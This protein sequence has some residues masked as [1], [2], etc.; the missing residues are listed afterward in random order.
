MV[1]NASTTILLAKTKL[2][3]TID[4]QFDDV[5][6]STEVYR[7]TV[8]EPKLRYQDAAITEGE[9]GDRRIKVKEVRDS[10]LVRRLTE[11][12][13]MSKGEAETIAL[14][15]QENAKLI[16]T[17]DYQCMRAATAL[18]MPLTQAISLVVALFE[19]GKLA[20]EKALEA[21]EKLQEY[22]WYADW[23]IED[24]KNKVR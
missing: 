13:A 15:I 18:G 11:D 21:V 6:I 20:K 2:L 16:A 1:M 19:A 3:R 17:D 12:F 7:E 14:A 10:K 22:G 5:L 8:G 9:V 24:A 4:E 23:I